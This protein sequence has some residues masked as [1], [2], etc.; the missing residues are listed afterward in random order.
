M[1]PHPTPLPASGAR[2]KIELG[3]FVEGRADIQCRRAAQIAGLGFIVRTAAMHCAA[4]VP[5]H[6]IAD[7]LFVAVDE[8]RP[9]GVQIE[10]VEQDAAIGHR[11]P[12]SR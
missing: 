11:L 12:A 8:F 1:A 4:I 10:V 6:Q 5:D 7:P 9:G 3:G 2:E